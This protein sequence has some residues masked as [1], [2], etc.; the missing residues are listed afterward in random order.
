[1]STGAATSVDGHVLCCP[2]PALQSRAIPTVPEA[3]VQSRASVQLWGMVAAD[4]VEA[5]AKTRR[6]ISAVEHGDQGGAKMKRNDLR[7]MVDRSSADMLSDI[8]LNAEASV[9]DG[10]LIG[11]PPAHVAPRCDRAG[12]GE[13]GAHRAGGAARL[14]DQA[15]APCSLQRRNAALLR[16]ANAELELFASR[17]SHDILSPLGSTGLAFGW[18][19]CGGGLP[20]QAVQSTG[21]SSL[22][23]CQG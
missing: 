22:T 10:R 2:W 12:D 17:V 6:T 5:R 9:A 21:T 4:I 8:Q 15:A 3:A 11:A 20:A 19:C 1:M 16:E 7:V 13:R 14:P 23:C 18:W